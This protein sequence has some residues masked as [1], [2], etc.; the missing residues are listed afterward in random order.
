MVILADAVQEYCLKALNKTFSRLQKLK[1]LSTNLNY[2]DY[3]MLKASTVLTVGKMFRMQR[4]I[5]LSAITFTVSYGVI[6][7]QFKMG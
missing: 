1:Y 2:F 6:I 3:K 7:S 5:I 4:R